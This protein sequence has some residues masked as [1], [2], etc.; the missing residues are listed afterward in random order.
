MKPS[1][2]PKLTIAVFCAIGYAVAFAIGFFNPE[3]SVA[4]VWLCANWNPYG[5]ISLFALIL[6][7]VFCWIWKLDRTERGRQLSAYVELRALE[8]VKANEGAQRGE[9]GE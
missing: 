3:L 2:C 9:E 8:N 5:W 6:A 7:G 4:W 1:E